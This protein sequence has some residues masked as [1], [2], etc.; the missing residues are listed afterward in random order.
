[1]KI[2]NAMY[3]ISSTKVKKARRA[4]TEALPHFEQSEELIAEILRDLP[5]LEDRYFGT[6]E[7]ILGGKKGYLVISGDKGLA[8][9]YNHN[10]LKLAEERMV[11]HIE[12]ARKSMLD[13][14]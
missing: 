8:G 4:L 2:T 10:I 11:A 9:A 14:G 7:P 13:E 6:G 3:L 12:N 1:M 5:E